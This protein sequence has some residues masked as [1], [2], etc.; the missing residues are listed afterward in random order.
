M[1]VEYNDLPDSHE[2]QV[3]SVT[4]SIWVEEITVYFIHSHKAV[5]ATE[6]ITIDS[7]GG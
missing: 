1:K 6:P 3:F 7:T 5:R 4:W 2:P